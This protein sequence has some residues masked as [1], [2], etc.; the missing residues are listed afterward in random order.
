MVKCLG[1]QKNYLIEFKTFQGGR[2]MRRLITVIS[3]LTISI[4]FSSFVQAHNPSFNSCTLQFKVNKN[5]GEVAPPNSNQGCNN[6]QGNKDGC[7]KFSLNSIGTITFKLGNGK[8]SQC[9]DPNAKF[10]ITKIE[11]S[12][13]G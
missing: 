4:L 5:K 2:T 10:V 12:H 3:L 9:S 13:Q 8:V 7:V 6:G 11:L 1:K